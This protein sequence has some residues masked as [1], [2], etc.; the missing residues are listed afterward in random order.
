[1][2]VSL[3]EPLEAGVPVEP[4]VSWTTP[5]VSVLPACG[6]HVGEVPPPE[7]NVHI[8]GGAL[9][10][11]LALCIVSRP[12]VV[13]GSV[14]DTVPLSVMLDPVNCALLLDTKA[15]GMTLFVGT[16]E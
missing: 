6:A 5:A 15:F 8:G 2:N 4:V 10:P 16:A 13:N 1:V 7:V 3:T 11:T 9:P 12:A 14:V